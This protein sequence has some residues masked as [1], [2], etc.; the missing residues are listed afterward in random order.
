M[1]VQPSISAAMLVPRRSISPPTPF[2]SS[3]NRTVVPPN[4]E[5]M[6][7]TRLAT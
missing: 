4:W 5:K 6:M 1:G 7:S 2:H 3:M